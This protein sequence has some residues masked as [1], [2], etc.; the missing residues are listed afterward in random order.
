M[1]AIVDVYVEI[2]RQ[3][4]PVA[5]VFGFGDLIVTTVL[6]VAFGGR[7]SFGRL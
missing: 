2:L 1:E 6:R 7:L 3:A 5:L 4:V